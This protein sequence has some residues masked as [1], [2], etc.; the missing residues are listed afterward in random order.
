ML[1]KIESELKR[2]GVLHLEGERELTVEEHADGRVTISCATAML[3]TPPEE[4]LRKL[5]ALKDQAGF[6]TV[7]TA[8]FDFPEGPS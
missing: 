5:S 2:L 3:F 1:E 4:I 8:L 6:D 7:W